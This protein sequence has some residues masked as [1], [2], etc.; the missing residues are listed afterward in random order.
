M[1]P[2]FE[3]TESERS[4]IMVESRKE[5]C[6]ATFISLRLATVQSKCSDSVDQFNFDACSLITT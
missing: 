5:W 4:A 3:I 6:C 2:K 1:K